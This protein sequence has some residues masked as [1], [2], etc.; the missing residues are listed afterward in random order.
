MSNE[1]IELRYSV[2]GGPTSLVWLTNRPMIIGSSDQADLIIESR[3]VSRRHLQI[4]L[5][6]GRV[7]ITDLGSRNGSHLN[8]LKLPPYQRAEW[9][10][11]DSLTLTNVHLEISGTVAPPRA[12][13]DD[14]QDGRLDLVVN[15]V[16]LQPGAL[17]TLSLSYHGPKSQ[18]IYLE[19]HTL[20]EGIDIALAP[21]DVSLNSG[22]TFQA[23]A[24]IKKTKQFWLGGKFPLRFTAFTQEGL[25]TGADALVRIRPRYELLVLLLL[26]MVSCG[27][28][29]ALALPRLSPI[30]TP[31]FTTTPTTTATESPSATPTT[32][33]TGTQSPTVT[34]TTTQ[35]TT[36]SV[37]TGPSDTPT[38]TP[39]GT[40]TPWINRCSQFPTWI[41]YT[42]QPGDNL[43]RLAQAAGISLLQVQQVNGIP[44]PN[45]I[46]VGQ[47]ICLPRAPNTPT[48][49]PT[50]TN[51]PTLTPS[52]TL[53][54]SQPRLSVQGRCTFGQTTLSA[55]F[56]VSNSGGPMTTSDLANISIPQSTL[57]EP[58]LSAQ[59]QLAANQN[60]T[61]TVNIPFAGTRSDVAQFAAAQ[62]Q[63][64]ALSFLF[65][66]RDS[67]LS[68]TLTCTPPTLT[69]TFTFTPTATHTFTVT[70]SQTV[71]V[72]IN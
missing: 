25:Y 51:T 33:A 19:G 14:S 37:T 66:T 34:P 42:I 62:Q 63:Q 36:P 22:E 55:A 65:T 49:T 40:V 57:Q 4:T 20:A 32:T 17:A 54:R 47:R 69:P 53:T 61:F 11:G 1:S 2:D 35:T 43:L 7:Y 46:Q 23:K 58:L 6:N 15:P 48:F 67:G 50:P 9:R 3:Y 5:V 12:E 30:A 31:T 44:D 28:T 13:G 10:P 71:P 38:L 56:T 39:T 41:F 45:R 24:Q 70:P 18:H 16:V 60:Q 27:V 68:L 64:P 72:V 29:A 21:S 8:G 59:F 26:L 52:I